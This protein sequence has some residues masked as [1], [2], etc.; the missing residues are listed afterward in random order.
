MKKI[1]ST[2]LSAAMLISTFTCA[3]AEQASS[4]ARTLVP[5]NVNAVTGGS[6]QGNT[7]FTDN[8][9]VKMEK[10]T[11]GDNTYL[12]LSKASSAGSGY[13]RIDQR[14]STTVSAELLNTDQ[15]YKAVINSKLRADSTEYADGEWIYIALSAGIPNLATNTIPLA[16]V[17]NVSSADKRQMIKLG[18]INADALAETYAEGG[19]IDFEITLSVP[20][21]KLGDSDIVVVSYKVNGVQQT[22]ADYS[23]TRAQLETVLGNASPRLVYIS[24]TSI[25]KGTALADIPDVR[26]S[27]D[28]SGMSAVFEPEYYPYYRYIGFDDKTVGD[29]EF[30][31]SDMYKTGTIAAGIPE[32]GAKACLKLAANNTQ[33]CFVP[34]EQNNIPQDNMFVFETRVYPT[35][36]EYIDDEGNKTIGSNIRIDMRGGEKLTDRNDIISV[37]TFNNSGNIYL[38][39]RDGSSNGSVTMGKWQP[40]Q[41]YNVMLML[42]MKKEKMYARVYTDDLSF[43]ISRVVDTPIGLMKTY[44]STSGKTVVW[45]EVRTVGMTSGSSQVTYVDYMRAY[46]LGTTPSQPPE[47]GEFASAPAGAIENK[48]SIELFTASE[49]VDTTTVTPVITCNG[50]AVPA[51]KYL[52][53]ASG[54]GR[55]VRLEPVTSWTKGAQYTLGFADGAV[56]KD[57]YGNEAAV[58]KIGSEFAFSIHEDIEVTDVYQKAE[59]TIGVSGVINVYNSQKEPVNTMIIFAAYDKDGVLEAAQIKYPVFDNRSAEYS[60]SLDGCANADSVRLFWWNGELSPVNSFAEKALNEIE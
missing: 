42:D 37:L 4:Q 28:D 51:D 2:L 39:Q 16:A 11:E 30:N 6:T 3:G 7:N 50:E 56:F 12:S 45:D 46:S 25:V 48:D 38:R 34:T 19:F 18:G 10:M 23:I 26:W 8:N 49:I 17:K 36:V 27:I 59:N 14:L 32:D 29:N 22:V 47:C 54:D 58:P 40:K 13:R 57:I 9:A 52:I 1:I 21:K 33:F 41:W 43:D 60:L 44:T 31:R 15:A 5:M 35:E 55:S 53:K 24:G 20:E